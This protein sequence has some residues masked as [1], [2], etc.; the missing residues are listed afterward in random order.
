MM[1]NWQISYTSDYIHRINESIR[2][3]MILKYMAEKNEDYL[4]IE[5]YNFYTHN[6]SFIVV[7]CPRG[8]KDHKGRRISLPDIK[9]LIK[10]LN[11][12]IGDDVQNKLKDMFG[13]TSLKVF[14]YATTMD[15]IWKVFSG[16]NDKHYV[17]KCCI[18]Y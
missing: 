3:Y 17:I 13:N 6:Y 14:F 11:S 16:D 5:R 12:D 15:T 8:L 9:I 7:E 18:K 2:Q 1:A 4:D 10:M